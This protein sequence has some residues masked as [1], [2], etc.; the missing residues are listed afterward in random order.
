[1]TNSLPSPLR[2][3]RPEDAEAA[4][5]TIRAAFAT[6]PGLPS[7]AFG[8]TATALA[9]QIAEG[10]GCCVEAPD[11]LAAVL[12]WEEAEGG[13]YLKRLAVRPGHRRR[14]LAQHLLQAAA[15]EA[16]RRGRPRLWLRVRAQLAGN[17]RLFARAGFAEIARLPH[18]RDAAT[19]VAVMERRL[20]A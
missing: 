18:E 9:R 17:L 12:L 15:E 20:S 7:S 4:L 13:L 14:G 8:E 3:L 16:R 19:L 6:N 2:P 11:G 1:M 10:G 5:A